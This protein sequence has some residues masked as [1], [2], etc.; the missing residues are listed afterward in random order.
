MKTNDKS[1]SLKKKASTNTIS[2]NNKKLKKNNFDSKK[3]NST[4]FANN[5]KQNENNNTDNKIIPVTTF[6]LSNKTDNNDGDDDSILNSKGTIDLKY[7]ENIKITE[8]KEELLLYSETDN[9]ISLMKK[10]GFSNEEILDS[11]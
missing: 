4:L 2:I 9:S 8:N 7:I 5:D 10:M 3:S 6:T 1:K 11:F